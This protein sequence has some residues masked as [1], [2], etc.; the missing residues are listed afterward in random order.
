MATC[1]RNAYGEQHHVANISASRFSDYRNGVSFGVFLEPSHTIA[2]TEGNAVC[3]Q[4]FLYRYR[5]LW[6]DGWH[7]LWKHLNYGDR[8]AAP[9]QVLSRLQTNEAPADYDCP[10][11]LPLGNLLPYLTAVGDCSQA[12]YTGQ[13]DPRNGRPNR[14]CSGGKY[15]GIIAFPIH[16]AGPVISHLDFMLLSID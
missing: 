4:M 10:L 11:C 9:D 15:Q 3:S 1:V 16:F 2:Q 13:V 6:I 8:E 7:N 12:E 14:C 5:H